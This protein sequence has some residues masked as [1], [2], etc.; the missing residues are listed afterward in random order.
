MWL[1]S[2]IKHLL[3]A[4][5]YACP[6]TVSFEAEGWVL[7]VTASQQSNRLSEAEQGLKATAGTWPMRMSEL[8]ASLLPATAPLLG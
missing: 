4:G 6:G 7:V 8:T 3:Y 5:H 1:L 2:F